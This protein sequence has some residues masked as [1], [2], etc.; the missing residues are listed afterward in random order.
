MG[1]KYS[2]KTKR[3]KNTFQRRG[4]V[5]TILLIKET[6]YSGNKKIRGRATH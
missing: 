5:K 2:G 4:N 6:Y 1:K 3:Q